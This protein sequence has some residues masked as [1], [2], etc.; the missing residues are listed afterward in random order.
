MYQGTG[1]KNYPQE[2]IHLVACLLKIW[3][4]DLRE[5]WLNNC[6]VNMVGRKGAFLP[7]DLFCEYVIREL[8]KRKNP[9][10]NLLSSD[11][12]SQTIA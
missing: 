7:L 10:S 3:G 9:T 6:L 2:M 1:L 5:M 11:Y 8:K 4:A 12:W